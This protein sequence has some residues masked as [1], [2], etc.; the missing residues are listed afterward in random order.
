MKRFAI[1]VDALAELLG[2]DDA[3]GINGALDGAVS[4]ELRSRV[5]LVS[6]RSRGAFFT[7]QHLATYLVAHE[8]I[9]N[10]VILDPA[11]GAGDL[12]LA[13]ASRLPLKRTVSETLFLWGQRLHGTDLEDEFVRASRLRLALLA[14]QRLKS[15]TQLSEDRIADLLPDVRVANGQRLQ[16]PS[17]GLIVL[18]PPYGSVAAPKRIKWAAEGQ[19]N[20]ASLFTARVLENADEGA[21]LV[22]IL[23]DVLRSGS[24]YAHWRNYTASMLRIDEVDPIGQ[25]DGWADVDVFVLRGVVKA[26]ARTSSTEWVVEQKGT[27]IGDYFEVNVG[28]VVPH[29]DPK[30]GPIAPYITVRD[31]PYGG[32]FNSATASQRR[33]DGRLFDPPFVAVRRT[34]RPGQS[35]RRATATV[36]TGTS[37]VAVENH[38]LVCTPDTGTLKSCRELQALLDSD[39]LDR[40]LDDRIRCR[41][42]TVSALREA[43]WRK[44]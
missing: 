24:R 38:L 4:Q 13:A 29:R 36:V 15:R 5:S 12:L 25:F 6:R 17:N 37:S 41:H 33:F 23:P 30:Q 39:R 44:R 20:R 28:A 7:A 31:L 8:T 43:P 40:W 32:A 9:K 21:R 10:R 14:S 27:T 19:I 35:G 42:L 18:N 1:Y 22:A 34:S 11:V 16:T 26:H 2:S 3:E